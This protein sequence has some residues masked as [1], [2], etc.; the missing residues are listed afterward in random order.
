MSEIRKTLLF[1]GVAVVLAALAFT[2]AVL[3][4]PWDAA[5]QLT[6]AWNPNTEPY[7]LGYKVYYGTASRTYA[8]S[9]DVGNMASHTFAGLTPGVT[10]YF[11]VTA[12]DTEHNESD[13]SEEAIGKVTETIQPPTLLT[14]P[15]SAPAGTSS[16]Y[17]TG[18]AA[19]SLGHP[20]VYQFDWTGNGTDFSPWGVSTQSKTWPVSGTYNVRVRARCSEHANMVSSWFGPLTVTIGQNDFPAVTL[21]SPNGGEVISSGSVYTIRWGAPS[22]AVRFTLFYSLNGGQTWERTHA[23]TYV[24]GSSYSWRVP[25]VRK[26]RNQCFV[27]VTGYDVS[28]K[29]VGADRSA[30]PFKV[31]VISLTSPAKGESL[32]AGI[33][34]TITWSTGAPQRPVAK[35]ILYSTR[36]GGLTWL[37][38]MTMKNSTGLT[39]PGSHSYLWT[40]PSVATVRPQCRVR[41]E[42]RDTDG[43]ILG[44]HNGDGPF[45]IQP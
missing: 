23:E 34:Y 15:T 14:G 28:G 33:P 6:L 21:L 40:V 7:L 29:Q 18:G 31:R 22:V 2:S 42:L 35:V 13:F 3:S 30:G 32:Q 45:T 26:N 19:S 25:T 20:V 41:I 8:P 1:C 38:M 36:D 12:Y 43:N 27:R 39:A 44:A 16:T 5:A 37:P 17:T 24:T 9:I 11:A 10:Y 4:C